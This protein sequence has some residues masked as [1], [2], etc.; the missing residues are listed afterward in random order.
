MKKSNLIKVLQ[1]LFEAMIN[2]NK[3]MVFGHHGEFI[4]QR[5][6]LDGEIDIYDSYN[7]KVIEDVD[8]EDVRVIK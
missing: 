4:I 7:D 2:K 1:P 6:G 3:V 8:Y 5:I